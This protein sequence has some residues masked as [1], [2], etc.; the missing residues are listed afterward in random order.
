MTRKKGNRQEGPQATFQDWC[1]GESKQWN[2]NK[3]LEGKTH[4]EALRQTGDKSSTEKKVISFKA[5]YLE[6][7]YISVQ[8]ARMH[9]T[10]MEAQPVILEQFQKYST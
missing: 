8:P 4:G 6:K 7:K 2:R 9:D 3:N 10:K 5:C 1:V